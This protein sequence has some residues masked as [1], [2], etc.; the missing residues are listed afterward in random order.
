VQISIPADSLIVLA[1]PAG[2]GKSTFAAKHFSTTQVVSSDQ[3]RAL[4][5]DD[6][7][8]QAVTARAFELMHYIVRNRLQSGRLTVAD[9]TNLKREDRAPF[10]ALAHRF[11]FKVVL[12]A[13]NVSLEV[14][15]ARNRG[16]ARV[17]PEDALR[18]QHEL[19]ESTLRSIERE[20]FDSVFVLDELSQETV[21]LKVGSFTRPGREPVQA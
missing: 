20:R 13:F 8:N 14:C 4:I 19:L 15:L 12:I 10:I 16:R 21:T 1:G 9:A 11:Q 18:D 6:P 5:C 7:A 2:S 17:V 3:C